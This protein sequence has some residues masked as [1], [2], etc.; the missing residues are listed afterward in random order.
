MR[1]MSKKKN[2]IKISKMK[3]KNEFYSLKKIYKIYKYKI[4]IKK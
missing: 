3:M 1:I 2:R 4:M